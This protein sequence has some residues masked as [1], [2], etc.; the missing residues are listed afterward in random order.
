ML[1][2]WQQALF[3]QLTAQWETLPHA[4]LLTGRAGIGKLDFARTLAQSFLCENPTPTHLPCGECAGC[5][6]VESGHHP[7]LTELTPALPDGKKSLRTLEQIKID[8]V[9]A[10]VESVWLSSHRGGLKVVLVHPAERMNSNAA[11]ALLKVLEEP[12][13]AVRFILVA[14]HKDRLLPTIKS[15]C[16]LVA[17]PVP[18]LHQA[19]QWCLSQDWVRQLH[20]EALV[21]ELLAF[22]GGVPLFTYDAEQTELRARL[23]PLLTKPRLIGI[24]D[25]AAQFDKTKWPLAVFLEW[26]DKWVYDVAAV[27][28][29]VPVRFYP[30][31]Q[32]GLEEVADKVDALALA[33][34]GDTV[35][36]LIPYGYHTLN[37]KLQIEALLMDYLKRLTR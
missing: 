21:H 26:L 5:V 31:A 30:Q 35:H 3:T 25:F 1:Y 33:A 6:L 8:A 32:T 14:E 37:V 28:Q 22:H 9:R 27:Q 4:L 16:R 23:L 12:P 24:L 17:M 18:P 2:P 36:A 10:V 29:G 7:D 13:P 19:A 34:F 11:N 15:R 20:D